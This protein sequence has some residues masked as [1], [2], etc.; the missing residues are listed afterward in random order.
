MNVI[1]RRAIVDAQKR[2]PRSRNWLDCWW[3]TAKR[4]QWT[5]LADVRTTYAS[6][7]H[8]GRF[9]VF[10]APEARRLIVGVRYARKTPPRGGTLFVKGLLTHAEYDRAQWK[11]G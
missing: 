6:A 10:D 5:S 1:C 2:F 7:D 3:R 9:L 11:Q 8:V 4:A